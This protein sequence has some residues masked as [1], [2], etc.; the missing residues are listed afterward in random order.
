[1]STKGQ[2]RAGH[3]A[4]KR[5]C[6]IPQSA[7]RMALIFV[8]SWCIYPR[9][10]VAAPCQVS[11]PAIAVTVDVSV[12]ELGEAVDTSRD[13]LD[14]LATAAGKEDHRPVFGLYTAV[15]AYEVHLKSQVQRLGSVLFC[16]APTD[17]RIVLKLT[18]RMIHLAHETSS[19][20]CLYDVAR[21]HARLHAQADERALREKA[22]ALLAT[23]RAAL[24]GI[25]LSTA[26]SEHAAESQTAASVTAQIEKELSSVDQLR[27]K[28][29]ETIDSPSELTRLHNKCSMRLEEPL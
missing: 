24:P 3:S 5:S 29:S 8:C 14:R 7:K 27:K 21:D 16:A 15:I 17:V 23:L 28:L 12:T 1:M 25:P 18:D 13:E 6:M 22:P 9:A 4:K 20:A 19:N 2:G 26:E 10:V 11:T